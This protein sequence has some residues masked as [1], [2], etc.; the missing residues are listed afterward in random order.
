MSPSCESNISDSE[1]RWIHDGM[2]KGNIEKNGKGSMTRPN[3]RSVDKTEYDGT[4]R[5]RANLSYNQYLRGWMSDI[6]ASEVSSSP[7]SSPEDRPGA[8]S[9][10]CFLICRLVDGD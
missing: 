8:L 9:R 2:V 4:C 1:A 5:E 6:S 3:G 7:S 10:L